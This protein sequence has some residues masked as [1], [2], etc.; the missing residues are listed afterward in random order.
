MTTSEILLAFGLS[1]SIV[2]GM[3]NDSRQDKQIDNLELIIELQN[4]I[5]TKLL[6]KGAVDL[7]LQGKIIQE[8][9]RLKTPKALRNPKP[10]LF[11]KSDIDF[12]A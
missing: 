2:I 12:I 7:I 1:A 4:A 10:G 5:D 9:N 6:K 11:K 3:F 8:I